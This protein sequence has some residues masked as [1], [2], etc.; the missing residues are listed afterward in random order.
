FWLPAVLMAETV[1]VTTDAIKSVIADTPEMSL[2]AG[3]KA[4]QAQDYARARAIFA[5]LATR[6]QVEA[7]TNLATL[8]FKGLGV[9]QDYAEAERWFRKAAAH[10][11]AMAQSKLGIMAYYGL[12]MDKNADKAAE[13][14]QR[15]AQQGETG[16][17]TILATLYAQG[18]GV[19]RNPVEAYF[20]YTLAIDGGNDSALAGRASVV[21]ELT[22]GEL[23]AVLQRIREW[24]Q[25]EMAQLKKQLG[26]KEVSATTKSTA[27]KKSSSKKKQARR[28]RQ[29]QTQAMPSDMNAVPSVA[30]LSLP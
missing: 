26:V 11:D 13:W 14:F 22:P 29:E 15:A 3:I 16:A 6:D 12:G 21:D 24:R 27:K 9:P 10:G 20:W 28:L 4:A 18:E 2:E 25:Q 23:D 8:Y 1:T 5:E 30:P 7:Q 17:Q 19:M